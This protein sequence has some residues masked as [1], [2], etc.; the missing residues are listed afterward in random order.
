MLAIVLGCTC[1]R[2][3]I[4]A[5]P[6]ILVQNDHC[7]L[8]TV[9][10]KPLHQCPLHLQKMR[11]HKY[12]LRIKPRKEMFIADA[13]SQGTSKH[14]MNQDDYASTLWL[15]DK[16]ANPEAIQTYWMHCNEIH[17]E[18]YLLSRPTA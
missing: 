13:L 2:D 7:P 12:S 9:L 18:D 15:E 14:A 17:A 11:L 8:E 6:C 5:Q 16:T 4:F 1:F 3:H 10:K